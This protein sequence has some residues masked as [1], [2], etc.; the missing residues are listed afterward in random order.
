[1]KWF[2]TPITGALTN[3]SGVLHLKAAA[4]RGYCWSASATGL[5]AYDLYYVIESDGLI[6]N[7]VTGAYRA[8]G[9]SIRC[10]REVHN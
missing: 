1:M 5:N 4:Y 3:S 2:G 10:V 8:A 9:K 7:V 6:L